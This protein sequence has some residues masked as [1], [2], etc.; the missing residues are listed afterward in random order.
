VQALI[1]DGLARV[2]GR[3]VAASHRVRAGDRVSLAVPESAPPARLEPEDLP[4]D[5]VFEDRDLL[6]VNKPA[7]LVVHPGAGVRH[8]TLAH[9]L[10]HHDP[11]I[12][13]VGGAGRPGIVH[14]LDK[15]TSGLMVVARSPRAFRA[16]VEALR[17]RRVKRVYHAI[18]WGDPRSAS[19]TI[20]GAI[21]RDPKH[22]QRMAMV[23]RGG[24]PAITHWKVLERYGPATLLEVTLGT[25]RTHQIR[26]HLAHAHHAVVGDPVYSGRVKKLLSLEDAQRSLAQALLGCL[27]RQALH[28]AALELEHPVDGR[29]LKFASAWPVDFA[30]AVELLRA[31]RD[32]RP[33]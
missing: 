17:D 2:N 23:K 13:A 6:V 10:L 29:A 3:A 27:P 1:R 30:S 28:A 8:G 9:A 33:G 31:F 16:L 21:G 25:G 20:E 19:S 11:S 5:I 12:A 32:H 14:R 22:R 15:D 26:V 4:L 24:K 7:G 18:V